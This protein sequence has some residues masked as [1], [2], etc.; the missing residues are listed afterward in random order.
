MTAALGC[1]QNNVSAIPPL[2]GAIENIPVFWQVYAFRVQ[3]FHKLIAQ[4]QDLGLESMSRELGVPMAK[5]TI[6]D[7]FTSS[8]YKFDISV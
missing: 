2:F 3:I 8:L 1:L 4:T 7:L 6:I 5:G